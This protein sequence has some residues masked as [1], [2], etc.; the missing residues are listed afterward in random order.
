[1]INLEKDIEGEN[2][3]MVVLLFGINDTYFK[4]HVP[5]T[6]FSKFKFLVLD[7][8]KVYRLF[9][10]LFHKAISY[11]K[12]KYIVRVADPPDPDIHDEEPKEKEIRKH[13]LVSNKK[14]VFEDFLVIAQ[15][16]KDLRELDLPRP[17]YYE[18]VTEYHPLSIRNF[19]EMV[20]LLLHKGLKV[21][22]MQYPLLEID[23]M[24]EIIDE[25]D[26]VF[27]VENFY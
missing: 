6:K 13:K 10:N 5:V 8:I 9:K 20:E 15:D 16:I 2:P 23:P 22:L 4:N 11:L 14:W 19:N 1:L 24:I 26:R 3:D 12:N 18:G 21:V 7:K 27:F 17:D 25:R